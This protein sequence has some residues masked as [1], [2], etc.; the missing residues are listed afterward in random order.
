MVPEQ[1]DELIRETARGI[2]GRDAPGAQAE[3]LWAQGL[4]AT[5]TTPEEATGRLD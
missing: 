5:P 4:L 3:V 1:A 2:E